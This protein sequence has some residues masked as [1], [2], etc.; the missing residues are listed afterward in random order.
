MGNFRVA[1]GSNA[2]LVRVSN[3]YTT[4]VEVTVNDANSKRE[5]FKKSAPAKKSLMKRAKNICT[6]STKKSFIDNSYTTGKSL[7]SAASSY[8][9]SGGPLLASYFGTTDV[10][11]VTGVLNV[12][13][14]LFSFLTISFTI[15]LGQ[16]VANEN[17]SGRTLDCTDEANACSDG[18]IA[19]TITSTTNIY[20]CDIFFDEK[21]DPSALCSG[22]SVNDRN[23]SGGTT[24]HEM[25]H[26][27][28]GTEDV[29]YG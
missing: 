18:V 26:A 21:A 27:T 12:S 4:P 22:T 6:D 2:K 20:F 11:T 16:A 7:A 25:T 1:S 9:S 28:S 5:L 3:V 17:D 13:S 15:E 23:I 19:Y 10:S 29:G 8:A 14:L 24:L